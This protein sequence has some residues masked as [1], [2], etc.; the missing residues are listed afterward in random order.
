MHI[1]SIDV[2]TRHFG[3]ARWIDGVVDVGVLELLSY[4]G[5]E[6]TDYALHV[7]RLSDTGFFDDADKVLVEIQM[8][9]CMKTIANT[10]RGL[11]WDK[12]VRIAPQRVKRHFKTT[13]GKH[14]A[15]KKAHV[16]LARRLFP[17]VQL[18]F[19]KKDDIADALVQLSYFLETT[20][21]GATVTP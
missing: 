7:K 21:I 19:K 15:N 20:I 2:G 17:R 11:H 12:T 10:I 6:K 5:A 18:D 4:A 8:R 9:S 16:A 3:F 13:M 14:A 1:L